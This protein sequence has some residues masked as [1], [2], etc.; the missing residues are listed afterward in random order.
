MSAP[1]YA[2]EQVTLYLGDCLDVVVELT[3]ASVDAV[4]T[5]PP[6]S[7]GGRRENSRSLRRSM[8]RTTDD[9]EW[10]AGDAMSTGG[11]VWTMRALAARCR[12]VLVEGGHLLAFI[13]WRMH[14]NLSGALE[15]AD[16]RQQPTLVWDKDRLGMGAI[17]RNQHEWIVHFTK[18]MP[19]EPSRRDVPNVLRVAPVRYGDHPTEKPVG[20]MELLASVVC[21]LGG[22]ILDPFAGSGS[23][24][25]AAKRSG[26]S[27]IGVEIDEQFCEVI[28]NRLAQQC[29]DLGAIS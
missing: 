16:Y 25:V 21:P 26:R 6:Y 13:D 8:N 11:F 12:P 2:D 22:T 28:A 7:S 19:G 24:L 10:I 27:A 1:Y 14:G 29:L 18:G 17:F 20:L 5:D 23:T 4:I 9:A 3:P 15:S